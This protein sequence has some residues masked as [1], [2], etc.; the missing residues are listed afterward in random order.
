MTAVRWRVVHR[1]SARFTASGIADDDWKAC[2]LVVIDKGWSVENDKHPLAGRWWIAACERGGSQS[3]LSK[4]ERGEVSHVNAS[5]TLIHEAGTGTA[6][7]DTASQLNIHA[8]AF[9]LL[10]YFCFHRNHLSLLQRPHPPSST[11][12]TQPSSCNGRSGEAKG[13]CRRR[14]RE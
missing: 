4:G 11:T 12:K 14:R 6:G 8:L 13:R 7:V 9:L 2:G 10:N 5:A 1:E 3:W